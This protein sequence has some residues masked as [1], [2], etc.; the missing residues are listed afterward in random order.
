MAVQKA[1][2]EAPLQLGAS[3]VELLQRLIRIDTV[4]PPGNEQP[5]QELIADMLTDAG[6]EC[7]LLAAAPQRQN[8]VARLRGEGTGP[9]LCLLGHV[10]TVP[11]AP[12]DWTFDPW[13]GDVADGEVRGRGALDMKGQVASELAAALALGG[14]GWR[15][16]S[17]EL[18][19]VITADEERGATFGARWL[20]ENHPE[21]V[22]SDFVINEGGGTAFELRGRRCYPLSVGEKGVFRFRVIARGQAGHASVPAMGDNALLKLGP[23]I[24]RL[25]H[26]PPLEATPEGLAFLSALDGGEVT[27]DN[28]DA[29]LER[30]RSEAPLLAA[31][32]AEPMMRVTVVPTMST[33]SPKENVIPAKA[34][35]M[36]DCRVP[37]G[38]GET[39]VRSRIEPLVKAEG[40]LELSF[41]ERVS[42]NRSPIRTPLAEAIDAWLARVDP[43]SIVVPIAM[44]GFSDS[45]WFRRAFDAAVVYGF[46]PQRDMDLYEAG[47]LIHGADERA[48][49]S[50]I[51]LSAKF[52]YEIVPEMLR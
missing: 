50:D 6:F 39:E 31:Y 30:L 43:G 2:I 32:L 44:P 22:R 29:A 40:D 10:D 3:A 23:A 4:N 21:K 13:S 9:T 47:P 51:E 34:E 45:H 20:C 1:L 16:P 38:M 49:A 11:A 28:F 35:L 52:F 18:L 14:D 5:A 8:L 7:E 19:V 12:A 41:L 26:Q 15:P 48:K 27:E 17:G 36:I 46:S 33:A 42:G 25:S 24:E 37:L